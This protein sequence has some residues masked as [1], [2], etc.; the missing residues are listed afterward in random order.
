MRVL[1]T[2]L[3]PN[4]QQPYIVSWEGREA[5]LLARH[6]KKKLSLLQFFLPGIKLVTVQAWPRLLA[7][8]PFAR[9]SSSSYLHSIIFSIDKYYFFAVKLVN[10]LRKKRENK[11]N[12]NFMA[13]IYFHAILSGILFCLFV[14]C[15]SIWQSNCAVAAELN[16]RKAMNEIVGDLLSLISYKL[17]MGN[18][19]NFKWKR[20]FEKYTM[21]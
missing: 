13:H 4:R 12:I 18:Y 10:C 16:W 14:L 15:I 8:A 17:C 1:G 19:N 20:L 21:F 3:Q 9:T 11:W 2:Q 6:T 7:N 5:K